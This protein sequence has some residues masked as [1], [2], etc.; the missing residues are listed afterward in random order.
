[1]CASTD[2]WEPRAGNRPGPPGRGPGQSAET[3]RDLNWQPP[4]EWNVSMPSRGLGD[5]IAK[6][7]TK[8]GIRPRPLY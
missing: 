8:L 5:V 3:V 6:V 4:D 1:M 7:T 2:L